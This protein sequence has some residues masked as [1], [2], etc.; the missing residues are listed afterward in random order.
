MSKETYESIVLVENDDVVVTEQ[1]LPVGGFAELHTH[2]APFL[3]IAISGDRGEVCDADGN[4]LYDIDYKAFTPGF[5]GYAGP[6]RL[7]DT[8]SLRNTGSE[9]I[10]V[11]EVDLLATGDRHDS[12]QA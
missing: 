5:M 10:V 8:H 2:T 4:L 6:E 12:S 3:L 7:P 11:I 9:P 1:R